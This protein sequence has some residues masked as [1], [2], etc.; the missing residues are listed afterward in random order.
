MPYV[1]VHDPF[2]CLQ[3]NWCR[4]IVDCPGTDQEICIGCGACVLACPNKAIKLVPTPREKK[5]LIE[6]DGNPGWVSEKISLKEAL[7]ELGYQMSVLPEEKGIFSPCG[8]GG[9]WS[10]A[11]EVNGE[12][13]R[14]C[15][16]PV[17]EG[18]SI[19]SSLSK[20]EPP[21]RLVLDFMGHPVGGVGT[22]DHL[23]YQSGKFVEAVC[24]A[25]G[26]NFRCPTCYNWSITYQGKG[27]P[28]TPREAAVNLT[29]VRKEL[30]LNRMLISG[31]ECTLNRAW[32]VQFIKELK[33]L[34][35]DPMARLHIQTNGSLLTHSYID[36]LIEAGLTDVGIDLKGLEIDTFMWITGL[37]DKE[38]ARKYRDNAWEAVRYL[39]NKYLDQ[40]FIGI[41]I[42]YNK[43]LISVQE[44]AQMGKILY[45][46]NPF[47]QICVINYKPDYRSRIIPATYYE[48]LA[49]YR[50]LKEA[51]LK[52]VF[53]WAE[54]NEIIDP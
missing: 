34:N 23:R 50:A 51:G 19:K 47:L 24:L 42:P 49:V 14:A 12:T 53:A 4:E 45:E 43:D 36:E 21:K 13:K 2:K 9:C 33:K 38:L 37:R 11:L 1:A 20:F 10:C 26:C 25:A 46:I 29:A 5:V 32:L 15:V 41:G 16:T 31:G 22:P 39:T 52:T 18:M 30:N 8:V 7:I 6:V 27:R 44:V 28:L 3:C 35:P 40:V 17:E 48:T 54:G